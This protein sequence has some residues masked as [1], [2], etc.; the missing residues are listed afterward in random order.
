MFTEAN[1]TQRITVSNLIL[2][3][4]KRSIIYF[5]SSSVD[6]YIPRGRP[7]RNRDQVDLPY[8]DH[9]PEAN[10]SSQGSEE[11]A[12][13]PARHMG[14]A[15]KVD[16]EKVRKLAEQLRFIADEMNSDQESRL[17]FRESFRHRSSGT[18][19]SAFRTISLRRSVFF[20]LPFSISVILSSA[21]ELL[22]SITLFAVIYVAFLLQKMTN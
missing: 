12:T 21:I 5:W 19:S 7:T 15:V 13:I 1:L 4:R 11:V 18:D 10:Y 2:E 20:H 14:A 16:L 9:S 3:M 22:T 17:L 6:Q 8:S